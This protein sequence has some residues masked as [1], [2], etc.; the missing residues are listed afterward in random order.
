[1][2]PATCRP[3]LQALYGHNRKVIYGPYNGPHYSEMCHFASSV[4][5]LSCQKQRR[6]VTALRTAQASYEPEN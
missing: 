3:L 4:S 1:M 6:A 5:L 2:N